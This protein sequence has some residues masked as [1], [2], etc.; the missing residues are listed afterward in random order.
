MTWAFKPTRV[1]TLVNAFVVGVSFSP[2]GVGF[3]GVDP[4]FGLAALGWRLG[5]RP[6]VVA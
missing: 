2:R 4:A 3:V 5:G 6:R 1:G